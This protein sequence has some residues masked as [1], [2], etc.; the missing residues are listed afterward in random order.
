M[1]DHKVHIF[2]NRTLIVSATSK[3]DASDTL[4]HQ[5]LTEHRLPANINTR[6]VTKNT[7]G[8][9]EVYNRYITDKKYDTVIFVHDDVQIDT[10]NFVEKV[11][12]ALT[13]YDV[14]GVAGGGVIST[15]LDTPILWHLMT[16]KDT[17][18]GTVLHIDNKGHRY[19]SYFGDNPKSVSI[20]DGVFLAINTKSILSKNIT[21]DHNLK[22]FHHY[23]IKFCID[24]KLAGLQLSTLGDVV[25]AHA[26]PGLREY[27]P[28]FLE[29]QEYMRKFIKSIK[30]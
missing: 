11:N 28:E 29:S 21:F 8:L 19:P 12:N 22:G 26:S 24:C 25:I 17:Q 15:T 6:F 5:S 20:L 16:K 18:S 9:C 23:D 2:K 13:K 3:T 14:V 10:V 4:L 30:S 1:N 7:A 27:T